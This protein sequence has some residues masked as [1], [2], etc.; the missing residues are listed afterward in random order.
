M[1]VD[2]DTETRGLSRH[3]NPSVRPV[4]NSFDYAHQDKL[5]G[6]DMH[7]GI[8]VSLVLVACFAIGLT[9]IGI[10]VATLIV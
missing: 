4:W 10:A 6:D 3:V 5:L 9:M 1:A 8:S 2:S 7:A